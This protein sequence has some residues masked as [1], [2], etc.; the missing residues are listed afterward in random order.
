M[1]DLLGCLQHAFDV[2]ACRP[3]LFAMQS[4]EDRCF[5]DGGPGVL[6]LLPEST[7]SHAPHLKAHAAVP[8]QLTAKK[9]AD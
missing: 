4:S 5:N 7:F 6:D 8:N 9:V 2:Y 1:N 3:Q